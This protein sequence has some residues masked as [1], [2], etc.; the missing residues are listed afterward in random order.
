ML[1]SKRLSSAS[2][3]LILCGCGEG[4]FGP[5]P[6]DDAALQA[7]LLQSGWDFQQTEVRL[8]VYERG[9]IQVTIRGQAAH[10]P[11]ED[12]S[13]L[14]IP[15]FTMPSAPDYMGPAVV[16]DSAQAS[17]LTY[18]IEDGLWWGVA[19]IDPV[20][21][22]PSLPDDVL[23][24]EVRAVL[25]ST[26]LRSSPDFFIPGPKSLAQVTV[27]VSLP[28]GSSLSGE[29]RTVNGG[30][31]QSEHG[32]VKLPGVLAGD[33]GEVFAARITTGG[34]VWDYSSLQYWIPGSGG[35]AFLVT[36]VAL[37]FSAL[38]LIILAIQLPVR[39]V[40]E[41]YLR[42]RDYKAQRE[43]FPEPFF[44]QSFRTIDWTIRF[45][46]FVTA[47]VLMALVAVDLFSQGLPRPLPTRQSATT[48][49]LGELSIHITPPDGR[50]QTEPL[51]L[52]LDFFAMVKR[53][54]LLGRTDVSFLVPNRD[55]RGHILNSVAVS[56]GTES[57]EF[58]SDTAFNVNLHV[59][60]SPGD[61]GN[62]QLVLGNTAVQPE[63][64]TVGPEYF[65][66]LGGSPHRVQ[67]TYAV[68]G[69]LS[70]H[71]WW[72]GHFVHRFPFDGASFDLP[73]VFDHGVLLTDISVDEP[74]GFRVA[75]FAS[76]ED[77]TFQ[78]LDGRLKTRAIGLLDRRIVLR[79]GRH[80]VISGEL[81]RSRFQ[82]IVLIAG[83]YAAAVVAG[84][85]LLWLAGLPQN[86]KL[87]VVIGAIGG[88]GLPALFYKAVLSE[89]GGIPRFFAGQ[90]ITM[91]EANYFVV[92]ILFAAAMIVVTIKRR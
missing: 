51:A 73:L 60:A 86:S 35:W 57:S 53:P 8:D 47:A 91:F 10:R 83:P 75:A 26:S 27:T 9:S 72:F 61:V 15:L 32:L 46:A 67:A 77:L 82:Q 41:I 29:L 88:V 19:N 36:P 5:S 13:V 84:F 30:V 80:T 50:L 62:L 42:E 21:W 48:P 18:K 33:G 65:R 90:G 79:R 89:I 40:L 11:G 92:A 87:G 78:R 76:R 59:P 44:R 66:I 43:G 22:G 55:D 7:M 70:W 69:A 14:L 17:I 37:V 20:P 64:V 24:L 68:E 25:V 16:N 58:P 85:F 23:D 3:V 63:Q 39:R 49:L 34:G 74:E 2:F 12:S 52:S 1:L 71:T 56:D 6:E 28:Q 54:D 38:A 31:V 45:V 4:P 81:R